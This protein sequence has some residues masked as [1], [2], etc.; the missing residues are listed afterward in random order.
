MALSYFRLIAALGRTLVLANMLGTFAM[1]MVFVLGGFVISK[2]KYFFTEHSNVE[3]TYQD[4]I[5]L[6]VRSCQNQ[7]DEKLIYLIESN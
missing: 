1:L 7:T 5:F 6:N 3:N 4:C 2:S